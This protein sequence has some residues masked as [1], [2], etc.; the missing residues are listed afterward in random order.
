MFE[1][2]DEI[3]TLPVRIAEIE[4]ENDILEESSF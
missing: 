3:P 1:Q 4:E 2:N